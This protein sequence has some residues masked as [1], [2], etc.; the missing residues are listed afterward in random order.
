MALSLLNFFLWALLLSAVVDWCVRDWRAGI[1][2]Q[3][4]MRV[5]IGLAAIPVVGVL[6]DLV[7]I[8]L[9]TWSMYGVALLLALPRWLARPPF[10]RPGA[11]G[12]PWA[13]VGMAEAVVLAAFLLGAGFM[14]FSGILSYD[15]FQDGDPWK[16]AVSSQYIAEYRT[17]AAPYTFGDTVEPYPQGYSILMGLLRQTSDSLLYTLKIA[18]ALL[19]TLSLGFVHFFARRISRRGAVALAATGTLL[20]IPAWLSHFVWALAYNVTLA[21]VLFYVLAMLAERPREHGWKYV[22]MVVYGALWMTHY[23][24]ALVITLF[25]GIHYGLRVVLDEEL[26]EEEAQLAV[27]G[28]ALSLAMYVP[29]LTRQWYLVTERGLDGR[30]HGGIELSFGALERLPTL[31]GVALLSTGF[32]A[33]AALYAS[34]ARWFPPLVGLV[35]GPRRKIAV[36]GLAWLVVLAVHLLPT[37]II[38]IPTADDAPYTWRHF[39]LRTPWNNIN[40]PT[41]IGWLFMPL[42]LLGVGLALRAYRDLFGN[43]AFAWLNVLLNWF[44]AAL[45]MTLGGYLSITLAP[46]RMWTLLGLFASLFA[47]HAIVWI[48]DRAPRSWQRGAIIAVI[49][50][51]AWPA[52]FRD[53]WRINTGSR[54][55]HYVA[56]PAALRLY[57]WMRDGGLPPGSAV[58]RACEDSTFLVSYGASLAPLLD[59]EINPPLLRAQPPFHETF[60]DRP[61]REVHEFLGRR[62]IDFVTVGASCTWQRVY[63]RSDLRRLERRVAEMLGSPL[64][65]LVHRTQREWLFAVEKR[66][67]ADAGDKVDTLA[68]A[69]LAPQR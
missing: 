28:F 44:A 67:G 3:L 7:G 48:L 43:P 62:G 68:T 47:G 34:R 38:S 26:H 54:K 6:L 65:R 33:C 52:A 2:E 39:F 31:G 57:Q 10:R 13:R 37:Q 35:R 49:V 46:L 30:V 27:G 1:L 55:D 29:S 20:A 19:V 23:T 53:T 8:P 42:C 17:F 64:F 15:Y 21:V 9:V 4:V 59:R 16:Y 36:V 61:L 60:L 12:P 32:A 24:S 40:S 51:L 58:L 18:N 14:Y 22:G 50:S 63:A 66:G 45:L 11:D 25:L 56:V 41:G 5:G 69:R